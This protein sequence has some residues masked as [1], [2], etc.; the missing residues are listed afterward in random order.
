MIFILLKR[1][2]YICCDPELLINR[3][4]KKGDVFVRSL[5]PITY[6]SLR[7]QKIKKTSMEAAP[8]FV[9]TSG[10][11]KCSTVIFPWPFESVPEETFREHI[12]TEFSKAVSEYSSHSVPANPSMRMNLA[13]MAEIKIRNREMDEAT[14]ANLGIELEQYMKEEFIE[15]YKMFKSPDFSYNKLSR[16]EYFFLQH[17]LGILSDQ[18]YK[19]TGATELQE[20]V[21]LSEDGLIEYY[22][23]NNIEAVNIALLTNVV[24]YKLKWHYVLLAEGLRII[25]DDEE[26]SLA[27]T[28]MYGI[29]NKIEKNEDFQIVD[30]TFWQ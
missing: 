9:L 7:S 3:A 23:I 12:S 4:Y 28:R 29:L 14:R 20:L 1:V 25:M 30:D 5:F 19:Q 13:V 10:M 18:T 2:I 15:L 16:D 11:P 22:N 6:I 27:L 24:K 26:S 21:L 8:Y 17:A